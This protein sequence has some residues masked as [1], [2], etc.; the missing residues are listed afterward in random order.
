MRSRIALATFVLLAAGYLAAAVAAPSQDEAA[1]KPA[2]TAEPAA[3]T[4]QI[5]L[6]QVEPVYPFDGAHIYAAYCADCH[7][8]A[9]KGD[10]RLVAALGTP[11]PD[12][13][14]MADDSGKF[15]RGA[16]RKAI[17]KKHMIPTEE[18]ESWQD[19]LVGSFG[20]QRGELM[21]TELVRHLE[22]LQAPR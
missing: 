8:E 15:N 13:T 20:D 9:G 16:A 17:A 7:G 1:A 19:V 4:P 14:H 10:G 18:A 22:T 11:M 21:L 2:A 6:K 12:L 5:V 3:A